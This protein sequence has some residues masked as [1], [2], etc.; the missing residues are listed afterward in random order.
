AGA[1]GHADPKWRLDRAIEQPAGTSVGAGLVARQCG[2][3]AVPGGERAVE[4]LPS[5]RIK[6]GVGKFAQ[7]ERTGRGAELEVARVLTLVAHAVRGRRIEW[8][9]AEIA[10]WIAVTVLADEFQQ[11][12][13]AFAPLKAESLLQALCRAIGGAG[14]AAI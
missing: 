5:C 8:R 11:L 10:S 6:T 7:P 1:A 9:I 4:T 3:I 2:A 14:N 12:I 13:I